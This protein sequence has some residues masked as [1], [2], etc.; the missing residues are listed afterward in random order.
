MFVPMRVAI[1][2]DDAETASFVANGLEELGFKCTTLATAESGLKQLTDRPH[3]LAIVDIQLPGISGLEL[4]RRL[5]EQGN[6]IPILILSSLGQPADKISG[7]NIGADDYLGKPFALNELTARVNALLR[8]ATA[9]AIR[10]LI[11]IKDITI[12][13]QGRKVV[14]NGR[15]ITLTGQ[16]YKILEYLACN[17]GRV[18]TVKMILQ[19]VWRYDSVP[20][21]TVVETRMC[22]L[23]KKLCANGEKNVIHTIRGFGYVL[24]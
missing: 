11:R 19:E 8:R 4:I 3:D 20:L 12:D 18:L 7:L 24:R 9:P 17:P 15:T 5:R 1:I 2:E 6:K 10:K 22:V 14:R 23:R 16:E 13:T 21:T